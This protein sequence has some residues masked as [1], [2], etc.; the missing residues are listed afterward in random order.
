MLLPALVKGRTVALVGG[1]SMIVGTNSGPA[2]DACDHVLRVNFHWPCPYGMAENINQP[3][4]DATADLGRRTTIIMTPAHPYSGNF[5]SFKYLYDK[6]LEPLQLVITRV[7]TRHGRKITAFCSEHE[8]PWENQL[9]YM[10]Q[11]Q[12]LIPIPL[13]GVVALHNLLLSE[14]TRIHVFGFD[15]YQT[16]GSTGYHDVSDNERVFWELM[17]DSRAVYHD[18]LEIAAKERPWIIRR[19]PLCHIRHI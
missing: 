9:P 1:S 18:P 7:E 13:T 5:G 3:E 4:L 8:I 2:I 11:T 17:Q 19:P 15:C 6:R 10:E 16:P 12:Q 14:A